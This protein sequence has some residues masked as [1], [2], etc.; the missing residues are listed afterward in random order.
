MGLF[1]DFDGYKLLFY[2]I[3]RIIIKEG[4]VRNINNLIQGKKSNL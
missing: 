3:F 1:Y 4:I 2:S